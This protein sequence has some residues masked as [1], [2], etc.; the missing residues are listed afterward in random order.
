MCRKSLGFL[1]VAIMLCGAAAPEAFAVDLSG[2]YVG[3]NF[4]R[5]RTSYDTGFIDGQLNSAANDA[6]DTLDITARSIDKMSNAWWA[7]AGYLFTPYI[8]IDA[9][10]IHLGEIKYLAAGTVSSSFSNQSVSTWNEITS[11]GP[12][13]SLLLRLPLAESF[14]VDMRI[15][16][17]YGKATWDN[18]ITVGANSSSAGA[19]KSSSSLLAGVGISYAIA[20]HLSVRLDYLRVNQTGDSNDVGRFSVNLGTVGVS[21]TF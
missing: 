15:G 21:Y 10:F 18:S 9:A 3:G 20:G 6:G 1:V 12:A 5:A 13:L 8:G 7:D 11:R 2:A 19:S 17:Y 4:G 14:A 16:D